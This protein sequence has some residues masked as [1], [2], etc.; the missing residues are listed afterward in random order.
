MDLQFLGNQKNQTCI[1][2]STME[3]QFTDLYSA[4]QEIDWLRNILIDI[5]RWSKPN[6]PLTIYCDNQTTLLRTCSESY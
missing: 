5:P 6:A 4:S 3:S 2:R 1:S